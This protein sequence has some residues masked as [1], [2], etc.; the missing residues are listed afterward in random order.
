[1]RHYVLMA[2]GESR[3]IGPRFEDACKAGLEWAHERKNWVYICSGDSE[4]PPILTR[5]IYKID[6]R[7]RL[8]R[9]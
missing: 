5:P 2:Q 3:E 9:I 4:T 8:M 6:P 1:M 7:A